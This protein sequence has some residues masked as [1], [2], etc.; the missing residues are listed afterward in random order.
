MPLNYRKF[1]EPN[2]Y[3]FPYSGA[4]TLQQLPVDQEKIIESQFKRHLE[5]IPE[6][7]TVLH[8]YILLL[9]MATDLINN[10]AGEFNVDLILLG[11][12]EALGLEAF[13]GTVAEKVIR[14]SPCP[15]IVVPRY[16]PYR[17]VKRIC[18][19]VDPDHSIDEQELSVLLLITKGFNIPLYIVHVQSDKE[20]IHKSHVN[21]FEQLKNKME[22]YQTK[23]S[24]STIPS[25]DIERGIV[26]FTERNQIDFLDLVYREH[27][28]FKRMF[29]PRLRKKFVSQSEIPLLILK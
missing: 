8:E 9:G 23:Y 16:H 15:A 6:I 19:A 17:S 7:S 24:F 1:L 18:L 2:L 3:T 26:K 11:T 4:H 12:S 22:K 25:D 20:E 14:K 28:F 13:I 5:R 10:Q 27:G 21:L 29:N